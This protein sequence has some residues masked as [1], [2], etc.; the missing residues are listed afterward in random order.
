[1]VTMA[2]K[3]KELAPTE[4]QGFLLG[5][6]DAD[7]TATIDQRT[8]YTD[9]V[10]RELM[11]TPDGDRTFQLT[12]LDQSI[13]GLVLKPWG[14]RKRTVFQILPEVQAR[15][16]SIPG[17]RTSMVMPPALPGGGAF[18]V[19]F[20]IASTADPQRILEFAQ[21]I[22]RWPR[23]PSQKF[24]F[25]LVD[26]KVDQP[27]VELVLDRDKVA[28]LGLN[29]ADVGADLATLVG[30]NFVNRFNFAGRSYKVIPQLK[31]IGPLECEPAGRHLRQRAERPTGAAQHVRD[32]GAKTEPRALNRFQQL[33]SVKIMGA[34]FLPLDQ[35][36]E[37]SWK[38]KR[39]K[40]CRKGTRWIHGRIAAVARGR[41]QVPADVPA[42]AVLD[43]PRA[44]RAVQQFPRSVHHH[45]RLRAAGDVRRADLLF[46]QNARP[47]HAVLYERLDDHAEHLFRRSDWSRSSGWFPRTAF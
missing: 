46:P 32:A 29:M 6:V 39:R 40:F 47:G 2:W 13:A 27:E 30:G 15:V 43:L 35:C 37:V 45:S 36:A 19:E 28:A 8:F 22:Q 1:M 10:N 33:N 24:M 38:P 42:S 41:Q 7:A 20:V 18:P 16:N 4:D 25:L 17:I 23:L 31:R 9:A 34:S 11:S 21:K 44:R 14:E 5:I 3:S 26:T 12:S